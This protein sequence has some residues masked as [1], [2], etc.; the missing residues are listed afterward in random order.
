MIAAGHEDGDPLIIFDGDNAG[1]ED[2]F[3]LGLFVLLIEKRE[4]LRGGVVVVEDVALG[5]LANE[6]FIDGTN[7]LLGLVK[8]FPLSGSG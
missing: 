7:G 2:P 4:D 5:G 1:G 3:A 8:D 6:S